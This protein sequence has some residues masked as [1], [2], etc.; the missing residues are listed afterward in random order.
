M[1]EQAMAAVWRLHYIWVMAVLTVAGLAGWI[2]KVD[3]YG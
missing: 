2:P 3:G 1:K